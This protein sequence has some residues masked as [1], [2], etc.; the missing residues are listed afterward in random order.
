MEVF[1]HYIDKKALEKEKNRIWIASYLN[2]K[3][4]CTID[5]EKL[6]TAMKNN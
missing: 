3:L 1:K 6:K 5:I 4:G 2:D